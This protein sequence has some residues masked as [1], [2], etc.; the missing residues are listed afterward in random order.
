MD[1]RN[2]PKR[3]ES[4]SPVQYFAPATSARRRI[5]TSVMWGF[6]AWHDIC[7]MTSHAKKLYPNSNLEIQNNEIKFDSPTCLNVCIGEAKDPWAAELPGWSTQNQDAVFTEP[8][9]RV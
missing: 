2:K 7:D 4:A 9:V 6:N 5:E 8:K 1:K 3:R